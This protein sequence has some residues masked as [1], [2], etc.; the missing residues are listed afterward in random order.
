M[1]ETSH[2]R[3]SAPRLLLTELNDATMEKEEALA[4]ESG[5][6]E[7]NV[8]QSRDAPQET[9]PQTTN[10]TTTT[11]TNT[12]T[13]LAAAIFGSDDDDD[14]DD[15][16]AVLAPR[17]NT[18][19]EA[20]VEEYV[21][22]GSKKRRLKKQGPASSDAPPDADADADAD[23]GEHAEEPVV[24]SEYE[25]DEADGA[26]EAVEEGGKGDFDSV[27]KKLKARRGPQPRSR[28]AL[29]MEVE[30]MQT[31]MEDAA[32]A[33]DEAVTLPEPM[34]AIHKVALLGEVVAML[35]KRHLHEVMI[36][37]GIFQNLSHWLRP[38]P[39]GSL[40]SLQIRTKL[41]SALTLLDVDETVLG[42]LRSSGIGKFVKMYSMHP[43]E[44]PA[45]KKVAQAIIEKWARPIFRTS[46]RFEA[47]EV[48]KVMTRVS[49][50][51]MLERDLPDQ[52]DVEEEDAYRLAKKRVTAGGANV[53]VARGHDF[54]AQP[55]SSA[56]PMASTKY[57]KDSVKWRIQDKVLGKRKVRKTG[58]QAVKLSIE[59]R[60]MS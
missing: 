31:R 53:P 46:V 18:E 47:T 19:V 39:D 38:M 45:T 59:G 11:N 26:L 36:D 7:Q 6:D 22:L 49:A 30:A 50:A 9:Q 15:D 28:D 14:D 37:M 20:M 23:A 2:N 1:R 27:L 44:T 52:A 55:A 33:D 17:R 51:E 3:A 34:P 4:G 57:V 35:R 56:K 42:S 16:D 24:E 5:V 21:P 40:V 48:P 29:Q 8:D 12:A 13:S 32:R 25:D 58:S 41:L 60:N 54:A 10:T 43:R